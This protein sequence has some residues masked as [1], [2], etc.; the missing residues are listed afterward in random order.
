MVRQLHF[1]TMN[2]FAS[3]ILT[4]MS[5]ISTTT[6]AFSTNSPTNSNTRR[7]LCHQRRSHLYYNIP[8]QKHPKE[9]AIEKKYSPFKSCLAPKT[10]H[11]NLDAPPSCEIISIDKNYSLFKSHIVSQLA[12]Q[13]STSNEAALRKNYSPFKSRPRIDD[14][15]SFIQSEI[16]S[17]DVS[18]E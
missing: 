13:T 17:A 10:N 1:R 18:D 4:I 9:N 3:I 11:S 16:A 6:A 5:S 12:A 2:P 8:R 14:P 7:E 15:L